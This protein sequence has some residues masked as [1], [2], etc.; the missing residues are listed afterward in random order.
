MATQRESSRKEWVAKDTLADINSGSF[1]R[2]ADACELMA[3]DHQRLVDERDRFKQ[4]YESHA[5][6]AKSLERANAALRGHIGRLKRQNAEG[7]R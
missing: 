4:M 6:W 1:Q 3:K 2:I 7:W 5:K